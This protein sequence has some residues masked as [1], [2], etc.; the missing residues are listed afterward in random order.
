MSAYYS[1]AELR[2][3]SDRQ[4]DEHIGYLVRFTLDATP[5]DRAIAE[6]DRRKK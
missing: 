5:L 4:L 2:A 6:R 1:L 3:R